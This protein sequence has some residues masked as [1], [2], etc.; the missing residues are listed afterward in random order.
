MGKYN[1]IHKTGITYRIAVSSEE[2]RAT[3]HTENFL[4]TGRVGFEIYR[5]TPL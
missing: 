1:I 5:L 3:T 2:D 4:T